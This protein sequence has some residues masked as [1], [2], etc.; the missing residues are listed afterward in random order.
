MQSFES[1]YE[2]ALDRSGG[3][4]A[5]ENTLLK[6]RSVKELKNLSDAFCLSNMSRRI[7]QAGLNRR[8]INNKWP[9]FEEVFHQFDIDVNR[10]LSDEAL[11]KLMDEKRIVRHW[12]KIQS[13]RHNA[14]AIHELNKEQ[15]SF[16]DYLAE[17]PSNNIVGFW[18]VLIKRFKQLGGASGPYFLRRIK[19]D[20]F[21]LTEDV[22]KSLM[23]WGAINEVPKNK[24]QKQYV[25]AC[26]NEWYAESRRPYCQISMIL[27]KSID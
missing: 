8:I 19:K 12:G 25:Q 21:L 26:M 20:T 24:K 6:P 1:I 7:F 10:V 5:L 15:G 3:S 2:T 16:I 17:W 27:A 9:A 18:D 11:E 23:H 14:Q 22:I 4:E 13:V